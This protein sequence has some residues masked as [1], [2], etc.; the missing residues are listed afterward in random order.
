MYD[1]IGFVSSNWQ[2]I[3]IPFVFGAL[4]TI[5][6]LYGTEKYIDSAKKE[7]IKQAKSVLLDILESKVINNQEV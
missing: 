5:I 3:L 1:V 6:S 4:F 2:T 7:R